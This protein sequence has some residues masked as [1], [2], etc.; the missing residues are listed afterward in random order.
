MKGTTLEG[1]AE[2]G[3]TAILRVRIR[4]VKYFLHL[5]NKS[6]KL[7]ILLERSC[8][9]LTPLNNN[10]ARAERLRYPK[11]IE[12]MGGINAR[13]AHKRRRMGSAL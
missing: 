10:T 11:S 8:G 4:T 5:I 12:I 2:A 3:A 13:L 7:A 6:V 1:K 9:K